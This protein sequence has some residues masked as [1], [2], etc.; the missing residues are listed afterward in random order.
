MNPFPTTEPRTEAAP[1]GDHTA[2]ATGEPS[3]GSTSQLPLDVI[4]DLLSSARRRHVVY[5]L[6]DESESTT[7]GELARHLAAI[8]TG[9]SPKAVSSPERKRVYIALYQCHL[10]KMDDAGVIGFDGDRGTVKR[11]PTIDQLVAYL[12]RKQGTSGAL[13]RNI[14]IIAFLASGLLVAQHLLYPAAWLSSF[15]A[16]SLLTLVTVLVVGKRVLAREPSPR[17]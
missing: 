17:V 5:Y 4:F 1:A 3:D 12:P 7:L 16:G 15:V 14:L 10:P 11:G 9:K 8:E 13:P 2:S 6:L